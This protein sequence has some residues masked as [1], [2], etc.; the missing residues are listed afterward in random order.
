MWNRTKRLI[1]SYLDDL[2]QRVS[3]PDREAREITSAE[4]TR[5]NELEVQTLQVHVR[6]GPTNEAYTEHIGCRKESYGAPRLSSH[7][8]GGPRFRT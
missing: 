7:I 4:L 3:G 5:L 2:I 8:R 1:N 6:G